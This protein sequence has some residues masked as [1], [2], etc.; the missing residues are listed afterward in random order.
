ML[1]TGLPQVRDA[2]QY[3]QPQATAETRMSHSVG[4]ATEAAISPGVTFGD[5][6]IQIG[7]F[8]IGAVCGQEQR[9]DSNHL[10]IGH[11]GG[12][13]IQVYRNDGTLHPGNGQRTDW[14][15]WSKDLHTSDRA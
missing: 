4:A 14:N 15:P 6:C 11:S 8:R 12:K 5:H 1:P 13:M 10:C 3:E 7:E 2:T 9:V